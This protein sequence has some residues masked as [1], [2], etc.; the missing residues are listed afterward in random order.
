MSLLGLIKPLGPSGFGY[1]STAEDVTQALSLEGKTVLV[2]GA[3]SGIGR[4]SARVLAARG[5]HVIATGRTADKALTALAGCPG[6]FT[7]V[8][9]E[10]SEPASVRAAVQTVRETGVLLDAILGNAGIMALETRTV[11]HGFEAQFFTNHIGHFIL[12]TGL[13]DRL[14]SHGRVVL[15]SS[16][17]HRAAP[18][19]GI[20]FDDLDGAKGYNPWRFYGQS[21]FANI[22]F[23]KELA[24]RFQGSGRV[25][26]AVHPGVIQTALTR[27]LGSM[28][29]LA[30]VA[31]AIASPIALKSIPEGAATQ[32][33]GAV[34]P[35]A[36]AFNGAYLKDCNVAS[37]RTDT[38]D[39]QTAARL[40]T[41]SEEIVAAL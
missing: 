25:A 41:R 29:S 19:G 5:A 34:H 24:R 33:W 4:E 10:L 40:W 3:T 35:D 32:V 11:Q 9:C 13:L 7:F 22:L 36:A 1:R 15:T 37:A 16:E 8:A 6:K 14:T 18:P 26:S 2:T 30:D 31:M 17:G 39:A 27:N 38:D 28:S 23:A 12:V 21:K 20:Y